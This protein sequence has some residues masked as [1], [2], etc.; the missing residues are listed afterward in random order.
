LI[1]IEASFVHANPIVHE[2]NFVY[3]TTLAHLLN[4]PDAGD[5]TQVAFDI[6][7]KLVSGDMCQS[8]DSNYGEK[9]EW[10]FNEAKD[11]IDAA[12]ELKAKGES[13]PFLKKLKVPNRVWNKFD[14]DFDVNGTKKIDIIRMQGFMK[15]A[16]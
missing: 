15:Y 11:W 9:V 5:R 14:E 3:L 13:P 4:N 8:I 10:W 7:Q 6:A 2:A 16:F 1:S 12:K